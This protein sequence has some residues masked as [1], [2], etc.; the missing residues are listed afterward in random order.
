MNATEFTKAKMHFTIGLLATLF[1]LHPFFPQFDKFN[2]VYMGTTVP[3]SWAFMGIGV[4]LALAV[5]FYATD[6]MTEQSSVLS[7]H[8]GNW[9]Y[10]MAIMIVPFYAGMY[11]TTLLEDYL[12]QNNIFNFNLHTTAITIGILVVWICMWQIGTLILRRYLTRKDWTSRIEQLIDREMDALKRA[13]ELQDDHADLAIIQYYKAVMARLKMATMKRGY[14]D[15]YKVLSNAI[16]SGIINNENQDLFSTIEFQHAIAVSTKPVE[17]GVVEKVAEATK[18]FL[19]T[20]A[21]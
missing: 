2:F 10:S 15:S 8:L 21:V 5:Y 4:C 1:A 19:A 17:P 20:V 12:I 16:H 18:K 11:L 6:L 9:F 13:K 3:L 7:H 14:F